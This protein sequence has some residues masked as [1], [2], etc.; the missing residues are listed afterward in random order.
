MLE[1]SKSTRLTADAPWFR[2]RMSGVYS[3]SAPP[4]VTRGENNTDPLTW[5][6]DAD[7]E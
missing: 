6:A 2:N 4:A 1:C 3:A 5:K 7:A